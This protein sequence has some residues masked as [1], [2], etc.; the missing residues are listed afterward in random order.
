MISDNKKMVIVFYVHCSGD[1]GMAC[2]GPHHQT[3]GRRSPVGTAGRL[4]VNE[5]GLLGP[6]GPLLEL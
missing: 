5:L 3:S 6:Q 1:P 2:P 4:W